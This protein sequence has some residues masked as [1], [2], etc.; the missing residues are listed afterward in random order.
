[1]GSTSDIVR[2]TLAVVNPA[3]AAGVELG[4]G[5]KRTKD[6]FGSAAGAA[7]DAADAQKREA[8]KLAAEAN[9]RRTNEEGAAA[10][11]AESDAARKRQ[12]AKAAASQGRRA[13]ILTGPLGLVEDATTARKTILGA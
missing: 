9:L 8:A 5:A 11:G 4:L 10:A 3:Q 7:K 6:G 1:M 12:L 13:T 2:A